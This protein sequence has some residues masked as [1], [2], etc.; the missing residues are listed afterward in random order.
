VGS[1]PSSGTIFSSNFPSKN[2]LRAEW[3][4]WPFA[5]SQKKEY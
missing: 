1:T 5:T 2:D 4:V 3:D